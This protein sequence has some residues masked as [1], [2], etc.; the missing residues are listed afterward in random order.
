MDLRLGMIQQAHQDGDAFEV[1]DVL[2]DFVVLVAQVLQVGGSVGLDGVDG[3]A[4]HG[5]DLGQVGVPPARVLADAVDG[6]RALA[7]AVDA[8]HAATLRLRQRRRVTTVQVRDPLLNHLWL[9]GVLIAPGRSNGPK[10]KEG[11]K[12]KKKSTFKYIVTLSQYGDF[13]HEQTF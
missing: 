8:G 2:F 9:H 3:V 10:T 11:E 1:P 4:E 5:D 6:W 13:S 12:R 7:Q